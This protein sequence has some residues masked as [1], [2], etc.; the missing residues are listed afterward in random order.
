MR[1]KFWRLSILLLA[2]IPALGQETPS[3]KSPSTSDGPP[4]AEGSIEKPFHIGGSVR[5]PKFIHSVD[6]S[7][8]DAARQAKFSGGVLVYLV[9]DKEGKPQQ[10]RVVRG[11][12]MGLDENA[13]AAV[14]QYKFKPATKDGSPVNVDI[15]IRVNFQLW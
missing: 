8:T 10:V 15:Y 13:V 2:T 4:K 3:A 11:I 1:L 6:P 7:F 9:V 14:K 5:P 12:G